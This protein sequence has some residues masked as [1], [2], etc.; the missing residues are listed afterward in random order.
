M[1]ERGKKRYTAGE[2][3]DAIF[4]DDNS[5]DEQFDC[6]SDIE[7][8]P[9]STESESDSD[10]D[11]QIIQIISNLEIEDKGNKEVFEHDK[12]TYS[13]AVKLQGI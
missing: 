11:T 12:T 4:V 3:L 1:A 13:E 6:G 2:V 8:V 9:D 5:N 7:A 10:L